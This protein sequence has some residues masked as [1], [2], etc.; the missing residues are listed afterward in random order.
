M[1][2]MLAPIATGHGI[3]WYVRILILVGM[4]VVNGVFYLI[5]FMVLTPVP[6]FPLASASARQHLS[7]PSALPPLITVGAGLVQHQLPPQQ[8]HLRN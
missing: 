6:F 5:A 1:N 2:A 7:G 3:A 4:L 8:R